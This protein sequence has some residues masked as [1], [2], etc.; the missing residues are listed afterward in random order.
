MQ[1]ELKLKPISLPVGL[2][3]DPSDV[4]VNATYSDGAG[5]PAAKLEYE[6]QVWPTNPGFYPVKVAFYDEVSGKRVEEKTVV[7][8]HEVE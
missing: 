8:V 3:F 1:E 5:V 4:V 7:T 2:R 6:G